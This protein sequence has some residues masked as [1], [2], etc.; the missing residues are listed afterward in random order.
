MPSRIA[1]SLSIA[2]TRS[3]A[4]GAAS[5][6]RR[7]DRHDARRQGGADRH[8]DPEHRAAARLRAQRDG[9]VEHPPDAL[10]DREAEAEPARHLGALVEALELAEHDLL[11]GGR[12]AE[13]G[14]PDLEH[15]PAARGG[16]RRR[17]RGRRA[18][19]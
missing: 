11:L 3:P 19:T 2:S 4:S 10:D 9:V 15:E 14:V 13:A 12:D 5:D 7:L 17:A 16:A 1:G 8:L 6:A 18:C